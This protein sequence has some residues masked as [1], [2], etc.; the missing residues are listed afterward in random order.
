MLHVHRSH[1]TEDLVEAL[2]QVYVQP[3]D[4][5]MQAERLLVGSRGMERWLAAELARR[6]PAG[7]FA[8]VEVDFPQGFVDRLVD[9]VLGP[10]DPDLVDPWS[11]DALV[12]TVAGRLP[13]AIA[14][15]EQDFPALARYLDVRARETA[16]PVDDGTGQLAFAVD[17]EAVARGFVVDRKLLG[18]AG[19]TADLFDRY[20]L[21]RPAMVRAWR[22]GDDVD[23]D[24]RPLRG[25]RWQALL[26]RALAEQQQAA[27]SPADR[28]A[29]AAEALRGGA[30]LSA[31]VPRRL[32]A[33]GVSTLPPL[34]LQFLAEVARQ[35]EVHLF[36]PS[37][38]PVLWQLGWA[39][40]HD[41]QPANALLRAAGPVA[42]H[43]A[44]LVRT[45][46]AERDTQVAG[47]TASQPDAH[48]G[49]PAR[50]D[51]TL[52]ARLQR[53]VVEDVALPDEPDPALPPAAADRS[54]V[55]HDGHGAVR[56][57]EALQD[58]LLRR[59]DA[60][61]TLHPRDV[62]VLTPD[63]PTY[64]PLVQ[65]VFADADGRRRGH[66][67]RQHGPPTI[68]VAV[69]DRTAGRGNPVAAV[70]RRTLALVHA[71][72]SGAEVLDLLS[73]EPVRAR[74]RLTPQELV[75]VQ[76]WIAETGV[77]WARDEHD[78]GF[79]RQPARRHHTWAAAVDRLLVGAA[80]ADE[81]AR[82]VGGVVPYDGLEDGQD[83]DLL[84][85]FTRF[86]DVVVDL[87]ELRR[88]RSLVEW[89]QDLG[90][91][92]DRLTGPVDGL[93]GQDEAARND[94]RRHRER[95]DGVL[96]QLERANDALGRDVEV[97]ALARWLDRALDAAGGSAGH[98]T[99]AVT[100]AELVP[101]RAIPFRVVCLLGMDTGRFPRSQTPPGH[102][103][104]ARDPRP[105]DRDRRAED[106]AI[107]LDAVHA[108]AD[109]LVVT[110]A[111]RDPV[112][113]R[114]QPPAVPVAELRDAVA[115]YVGEDG[116]RDR[117]L[118]HPVLPTGPSAFT[119]DA[120]TSY[121]R[122]RLEAARAGHDQQLR[123]P[124]FLAEPLPPEDRDGDDV[125]HL[126]QLTRVVSKPAQALLDRL[127]VARPE[128]LRTFPETEPIEFDALEEW[129]VGEALLAA[130]EDEHAGALDDRVA[131]V[132]A[133]GRRPAGALGRFATRRN[134]AVAQQMVALLEELGPREHRHV[135]IDLG[136]RRVEGRLRLAVGERTQVV[137]TEYGRANGRRHVR[138]WLQHLAACA[139]LADE[140]PRTV[141]Q[142]RADGREPGV[143]VF[144][145]PG[146]AADA[147]RHELGRWVD[148]HDRARCERVPFVAAVSW[149][150]A[151]QRVE[152]E[153]LAVEHGGA[154]PD[155]VQGLDDVELVAR[156]GQ[157]GK[158]RV[159]VGSRVRGALAEA[160]KAWGREDDERGFPERQQPDVR[161]VF[162]DLL[163]WDDLIRHTDL[164][165]LAVDLLRPAVT[166]LHAG[167]A[168]AAALSA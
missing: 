90:D 7:V 57:V 21:Y 117:T 77:A 129:Q 110:Y 159:T 113:G 118:V 138:A 22:V 132:L 6:S 26:W 150:F 128:D 86:L 76:Q 45:V 168:E 70:L 41:T 64:A 43:A 13:D 161:L 55:F 123:P 131:V 88:E 112:S 17:T 54:I 94:H 15:D 103:L 29:E 12:W 92:L 84:D 107:F 126:D 62:V 30:E 74:F 98:G 31:A 151:Q 99:G 147:A 33:F 56:Q 149:V 34:H 115:A 8:N 63:L 58:E 166:S 38:S 141:L 164:L 156:F 105:G 72:T 160:H 136:G 81:G 80:M 82:T 145:H 165:D 137:V 83:L 50:P 124:P 108:A 106:R 111:G 130:V 16:D 163:R 120:P 89:A 133:R 97:R 65:A 101:L 25:E 116:L 19:Q 127:R 53:D 139:A 44:H 52:L 61:P 154:D 104:V 122:V 47:G 32:V 134:V 167:E 142:C 69:A 102:D 73:T 9:D 46:A 11:T 18:F 23:A 125:L 10:P 87:T 28:I 109:A 119:A 35:R 144:V 148:L 2:A 1:R 91:L 39:G 121:D 155:E 48:G 27:P 75:T 36:V 158:G 20:A 14:E 42:R 96:G 37:P 71:R 135:R 49:F 93:A 59:F 100:V 4:D 114:P 146:M 140:Q 85:R 40:D 152:A 51:G 24:G 67:T 3:L 162:R 60:D 95:V 78:R 66:A 157:A 68:P 143:E 153:R 5:P 79:H